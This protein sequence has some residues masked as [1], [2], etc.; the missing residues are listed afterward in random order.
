MP[1]PDKHVVFLS[2]SSKDRAELNA[3]KKL[4][5]DRAVSALNF[6]LSSDGQSIPF[7]QNWDVTISDALKSAR[8]MFVFL[9]P[10]TVDSKWIHF[11]AGY[12]AS[13]EIPVVPVCLPGLDMEKVTPPLSLLQGFNLHTPEAMANIVRMC[14]QKFNLTIPELFLPEDFNRVFAKSIAEA[15]GFFG[16]YSR[17]LSRIWL[18]QFGKEE[19]SEKTIDPIPTFAKICQ[20]ANLPY[21]KYDRH[22]EGRSRPDEFIEIPGCEI[23]V[24][25]D[26]NNEQYVLCSLTPQLFDTNAPLLDKWYSSVCG[27]KEWYAEFNFDS[28]VNLIDY[29]PELTTKLSN[30]QIRAVDRHTFDFNEFRFTLRRKSCCELQCSW[31]GNL[32]NAR[33][34]EV[35]AR[36]FDCQVLFESSFASLSGFDDE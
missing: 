20:E 26:M 10:Q 35:I 32:H 3:L 8:L 33:L 13:R 24:T 16:K 19:P 2:H 9:S 34:S 21:T 31:T 15:R 18:R 25:Y 17:F 36:L 12:A 14:N 29:R 22:E 23:S 1:T 11:E 7:G 5:D 6:F 27:G 28:H 4:I 30:S